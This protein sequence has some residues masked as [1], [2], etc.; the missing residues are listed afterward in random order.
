MYVNFVILQE[1]E[2]LDLLEQCEADENITFDRSG[3]RPMSK[4]PKVRLRKQSLRSQASGWV[5]GKLADDNPRLNVYRSVNFSCLKMFNYVS[6]LRR[7]SRGHSRS[8]KRPYDLVKIE[9][10]SRKGSHKLDG[11][12]VGRIG[13]FSF[14]PILFTTPSGS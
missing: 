7:W 13:T 12:G 4:G 11:I 14:L 6:H 10:R 3:N 1:E 8:R 2:I 9:N 5:V